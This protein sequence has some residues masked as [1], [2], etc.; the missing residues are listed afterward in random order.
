MTEAAKIAQELNLIERNFLKRVCDGHPLSLANR[1]EDR[2]RQRLRKLGLVHVA[3]NPRR[4]EALP[5]GL[6]VRQTLIVA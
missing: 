5:L 4:W 6:L 3:K 1:A 2:A